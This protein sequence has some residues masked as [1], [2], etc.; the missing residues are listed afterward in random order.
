[1]K[2]EWHQE[3][4]EEKPLKKKVLK[5]NFFKISTDGYEEFAK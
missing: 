5:G 2:E 1:M 4:L 3:E